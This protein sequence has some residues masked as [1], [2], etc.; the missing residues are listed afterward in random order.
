M[1]NKIPFYIS[2]LKDKLQERIKH[3]PRYS[4][5]SFAMALK[6]DASYLSR[7]L[8]LKQIMSLDIAEQVIH[9][10]CLDEEQRKNFLLSI[11]E[12]QKCA[13]LN[14]HDHN[15]TDCNQ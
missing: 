13:C 1:G 15:L 8:S 12:Q 4:L 5:R 11:A 6:I 3:N 9:K 7:V 2:I 14:K 10:L